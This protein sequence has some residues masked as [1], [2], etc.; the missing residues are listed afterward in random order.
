VPAAEGGE[1]RSKVTP[2]DLSE[3][4]CDRESNRLIQQLRS[5]CSCY[6]PLAQ[7]LRGRSIAAGGL[8]EVEAL[9]ALRDEVVH[10]GAEATGPSEPTTPKLAVTGSV[11]PPVPKLDSS[12]CPRN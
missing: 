8:A 4:D 3:D 6:M 7:R 1:R 5:A 10:G 11:M 9:V 2:F 12:S